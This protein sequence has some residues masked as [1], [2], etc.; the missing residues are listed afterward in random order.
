MELS[1]CGVFAFFLLKIEHP[2]LWLLTKCDFSYFNLVRGFALSSLTPFS[3]TV[4]N[5]FI[6]RVSS[7][8]FHLFPRP[9][10][11]SF[12]HISQIFRL[13]SKH[14]TSFFFLLGQQPISNLFPL[15]IFFFLLIPRTR[16]IFFHN[17]HFKSMRKN[18][19]LGQRKRLDSIRLRR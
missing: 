7:F 12:F 15:R 18:F 19:G 5:E 8:F 1:I 14:T 2:L 4:I 16:N 9:L 6:T 10:F 13:I 17:Q 11:S 3:E